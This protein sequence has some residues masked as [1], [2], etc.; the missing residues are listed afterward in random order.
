MRIVAQLVDK[1]GDLHLI[2]DTGEVVIYA[3]DGGRGGF[4]A[5]GVRYAETFSVRK[6][7]ASDWAFCICGGVVTAVFLLMTVWGLVTLIE[8]L[9]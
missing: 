8:V 4:W 5:K 7:T 9:R 6:T 1:H 3:P 2:G